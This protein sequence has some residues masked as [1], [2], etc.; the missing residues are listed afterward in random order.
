MLKG[1]YAA[2]ATMMLELVTNK[3][4]RQKDYMFKHSITPN[5]HQMVRGAPV[6]LLKESLL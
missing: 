1:G 4:Q 6:R 5:A 3:G 2:R